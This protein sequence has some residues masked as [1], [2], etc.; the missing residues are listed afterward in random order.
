MNKIVSKEEQISFWTRKRKKRR[1]EK[2]RFFWRR[3]RKKVNVVKT[4]IKS[5]KANFIFFN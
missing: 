3:K 2:R 4:T 1:Y 5:Y